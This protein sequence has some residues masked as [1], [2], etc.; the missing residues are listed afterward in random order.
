[1]WDPSTAK[2]LSAKRRKE[3]ELAYLHF[4][5]EPEVFVRYFSDPVTYARNSEYSALSTFA[6]YSKLHTTADTLIYV[7][8][9]LDYGLPT[10]NALADIQLLNVAGGA[11][12][13]IP[14]LAANIWGQP[15]NPL[16]Q[17]TVARL[18]VMAQ[19]E[20]PGATIR[21]S[22]SIANYT[23]KSL[24]YRLDRRPDVTVWDSQ[25]RLL[26]VY[27]AARV[28]HTG[29]FVRREQLK[30]YEYYEWGIPSHFEEVK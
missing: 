12:A 4:L 17:A 27:E 1:M 19:T 11:G 14:L 10:A 25:G 6:E 24:G 8:V 9:A 2:Y 5:E 29:N 30:M 28:D 21:E 7:S 16:H 13:A 18:R 23:E 15:G 22:V 26:K 20:F 3:A